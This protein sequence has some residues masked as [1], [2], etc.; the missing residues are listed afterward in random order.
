MA[1]KNIAAVLE[2]KQGSIVVRERPIPKPAS[3]EILLRNKAIA[4]NPVDWMVRDY[5]FGITQYPTVL[6][7]DVSGVI[8]EIG[9]SVIKFKVGDRVVGFAGVLYT[10]NADHGAWQTYTLMKQTNI[11]L[12]PS[13]I[14]FEDAAVLPM[15][16]ATAMNVFFV[17]LGLPR[18]ASVKEATSTSKSKALFI[19]GGGGSVAAALIQLG[20]ALGFTIYTAASPKHRDRLQQLGATEVFDYKDPEVV[21]RVLDTA[22]SVGLTIGYA[23]DAT[24]NKDTLSATASILVESG[25]PSSKLVSLLP[26]PEDLPCPVEK[27]T[28]QAFT[29]FVEQ[30]DLV[31]W[32]FNDW[33]AKALA[34]GI[35]VPAPSVKIIDGG[36]A[37]CTEVLE[38][39]KAGVSGVKIVVKV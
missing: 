34:E 14:S 6:G 26:W 7:S 2:T 33:F 5:G 23:I 19:W 10:S 21:R 18:P 36:V 39:I 28:L 38:S 3:D 16:F 17:Q 29:T 31:E 37:S 15:A 11:T 35:L 20:K 22:K 12:L 30:A 27:L 24:S 4:G 13:N 25:G 8:E 1:S 9:S 32:F